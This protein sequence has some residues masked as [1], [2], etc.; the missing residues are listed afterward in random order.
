MVRPVTAINAAASRTAQIMH[1]M[2]RNARLND[3]AATKKAQQRQPTQNVNFQPQQAPTLDGATVAAPSPNVFR[4][5]R[6]SVLPPVLRRL[7]DQV[8]AG[9]VS[10]SYSTDENVSLRGLG[11]LPVQG[12]ERNLSSGHNAPPAA[13]A[14]TVPMLDKPSASAQMPSNTLQSSSQNTNNTMTFK[15]NPNAY[16]MAAGLHALL[17]STYALGRQVV[18]QF[19]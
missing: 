15:N 7:Q 1:V 5:A 14:S 6:R 17:G 9:D 19:G 8:D 13:R 16:F 10:S 18:L 2:Q 4:T 12:I 11:T 3:Q